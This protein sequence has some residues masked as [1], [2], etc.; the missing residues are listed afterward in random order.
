MLPQVDNVPPLPFACCRKPPRSWG[1]GE[2]GGV[3]YGLGYEEGVGGGGGGVRARE[4]A[5]RKTHVRFA[6]V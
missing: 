5:S 2:G 6:R 4:G 3:G 1:K